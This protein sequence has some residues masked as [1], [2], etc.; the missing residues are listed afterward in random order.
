M[1]DLGKFG[2][3][4]GLFEEVMGCRIDFSYEKKLRQIWGCFCVE[5]KQG[6][7]S[8]WHYY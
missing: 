5:V 8:I 6:H 4:L 3:V 2:A 7:Y 1:K